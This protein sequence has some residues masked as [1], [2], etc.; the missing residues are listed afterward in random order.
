MT[1]SLGSSCNCAL[2]FRLQRS[3]RVD[4]S[5]ANYTLASHPRTLQ[6][7]RIDLDRLLGH[8]S[9]SKAV[10]LSPPGVASLRPSPN[11]STKPRAD[12]Q[13]LHRR[14]AGTEDR[15]PKSTTTLAKQAGKS[16]PRVT[17]ISRPGG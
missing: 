16:K 5:P 11:L 17:P 7:S 8:R 13:W 2:Y 6:Q 1:V 3:P 15:V 9:P 14:Q 4:I 10:T 12:S